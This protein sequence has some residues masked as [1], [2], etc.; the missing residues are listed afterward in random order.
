MSHGAAGFAYAFASLFELTG[1][2]EYASAAKECVE[3]ENSSFDQGQRNWPD[4]RSSPPSWPCQWCHGAPGIGLARLAMARLDP[5][6]AQSLQ[7]DIASA[8]EA[9]R[10][11]PTARLDTLC[12]GALGRIE[13]LCTAADALGQ[14]DLRSSAMQSLLQIV[15]EARRRGDYRWDVAGRKYNIGLFR[16]LS[17]VG[18]TALRRVD[19][20]LPNVLI[21]Q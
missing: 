20:A 9:T 12:C 1:R 19:S 17:G 4:L 15:E 8:I 2:Q 16:G 11:S 18:Y 10:S 13:F 7:S 6:G 5:T 21:L 3:Y 14:A